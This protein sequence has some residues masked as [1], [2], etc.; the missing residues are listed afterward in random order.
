MNE[1]IQKVIDS[2]NEGL[3]DVLYLYYLVGLALMDG[4]EEKTKGE[5]EE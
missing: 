2:M 1:D 3:Y 5:I 4:K